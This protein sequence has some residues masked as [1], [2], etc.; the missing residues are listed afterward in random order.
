MSLDTALHA[1]A[2]A[3]CAVG[4]FALGFL[5]MVVTVIDVML[6]PFGMSVPGAY[7]LV[8][9]GMRMMVPLSLPYVFWTEANLIVDL[10]FQRPSPTTRRIVALVA[11]GLS[12][13]VMGYVTFAVC[14]R[15]PQVYRSGEVSTDLAVPIWIYWSP[16]VVGFGLA[17]IVAAYR[18]FVPYEGGPASERLDL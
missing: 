8:T 16:L 4:M 13:L 9:V 5:M 10:L 7:E 18:I 11:N 14:R 3:L 2:R 12:T 17:T 1:T 6:R 15:I